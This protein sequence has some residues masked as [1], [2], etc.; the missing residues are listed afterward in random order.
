MKIDQSATAINYAKK[1][2]NGDVKVVT[3]YWY[4]K[5]ATRVYTKHQ[6][7]AWRNSIIKTNQQE[8][9]YGDIV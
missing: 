8:I 9:K 4:G 6:F 1:L 5:P 2:S 7:I 3:H